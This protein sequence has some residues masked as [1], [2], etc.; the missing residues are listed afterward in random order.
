MLASGSLAAYPQGGGHWTVFLQYLFGLS[1]LGHDVFWLELLQSTGDEARDRRLIKIFFARFQKY[2]FGDRCALLLYD[3]NVTAPT[4]NSSRAYGMSA[5]RIEELA[6]S[7][8][9]LWNFACTLRQP[10]LGLFKRPVLVDGDPGHLQISSLTW[11]MGIHEHQVFL[12]AGTKLHDPDCDVP[13]LGLTWHPFTQFV[14]LPMWEPAPDPGTDAPFTSVTHWKWEELWFGGEVL[15][16][17]KRDAYLRYVDVPRRTGRPFEL[18]ANIHPDD[19][20]GDRELLLG[21]GWRLVHPYRVASSPA[22]YR[23]YI[24]RSR[25]EFL[26]PKPIHRHLRTGWFSDR[27]ACYLAMARPVLVE[28]TGLGEHVPTGE[29][30]VMF[31]DP[32]EAVTK[33]ADIEAN[34]R[35]HAE[36]ARDLAESFLDSRRCLEAMLAACA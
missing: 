32:E 22:S 27:S 36:A 20:T 17:S 9:F 29:G 15:S 14:Y 1:D 5:R 28:D 34:Y 26:C 7:A 21:H 33:V 8:D 35:R 10:L 4:L 3:K 30:L 19:A 31:R 13:T 16:V 23:R 25:G 2:G 24:R 11:E 6:R 18:A 12:T